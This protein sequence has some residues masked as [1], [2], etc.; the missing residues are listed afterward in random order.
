MSVIMWSHNFRWTGAEPVSISLNNKNYKQKQSSCVYICLIPIEKKGVNV[1][2]M[3]YQ[4]VLIW[5]AK[6]LFAN[7]L[8]LNIYSFY[9][10]LIRELTLPKNIYFYE[11]L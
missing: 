5:V 1:R 8:S 11:N 6:N 2:G 10:I 4:P 3:P 9:R 7:S